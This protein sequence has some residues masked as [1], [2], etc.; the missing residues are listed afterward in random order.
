M[1]KD[2]YN[3]FKQRKCRVKLKADSDTE[4]DRKDRLDG[5]A[6]QKNE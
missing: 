5:G 2:K 3:K 6:K 4:I 1:P